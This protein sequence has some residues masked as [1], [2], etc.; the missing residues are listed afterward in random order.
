MNGMIF[1]I[2]RFS[3]H[4]GP[5]I[6]TTVFLKGCNL[7][8]L[9]CHNPESQKREPELMFRR[10]K[11]IGCGKCREFCEKAFTQACI[12][13]GKCA[14]V[15]GSFARELCGYEISDK[16]L[17]GKLLAD[18]DFYET[19][20]GGVTLSGG[21]PL[22]QPDF[23][24]S[25]LKLCREYRLN[26]AIETAG[27]VDYGIIERILP[28]T[29]LFLFDI[30]AMDSEL[31]KRLTGVSDRRILENARRL[32]ETDARVIFRMPVIPGYNDHELGRVAEFVGSLRKNLELMPYH[33]M[34][35]GKYAALGRVFE[36]E[37]ARVM[38]REESRKLAESYSATVSE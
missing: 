23:V 2:Q 11:C 35:A 19:S 12:A 25:V 38:T 4:D 15:C 8:C 36:T 21:E 16:E 26:T 28:F 9:W 20:G 22:C 33:N 10:D 31:H 37:D 34:C 27:N 7:R 18:R 3:L 32:S 13:C 17:I 29:D 1:N 14:S 30:K 5:G 24:L 6:R